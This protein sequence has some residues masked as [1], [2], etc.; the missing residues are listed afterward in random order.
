MSKIDSYEQRFHQIVN[1]ILDIIVE[2]DLKGNF[3]YASPQVYDILGY[4]PDEIIGLSG[5]KF[6]HPEDLPKV[7]EEMRDLLKPK[8]INTVKKLVM[9]Y[10]ALHKKGYYIFLSARGSLVEIEGN[11]KIIAVLSDITERKKIEQKLKDSEE[12][13]RPII[14]KAKEGYYEVD[15]KGNFTFF[16]DALSNLL[17]YSPNEL[18]GMNFKQIMDEENRKL[19]FKAYNNAYRTGIEQQLLQY[20]LITKSGENL[21]GETSIY[22]RYDSDG[23]KIGFSGF[24]RDI[25]ERKKAEQNLKES[26]EKYRQFIE[27]SLEGVWA[28]DENANTILVNPSMSKI[29]GYSLEEMIGK[30]LFEFVP[31]KDIEITKKNLEKRRKGIKEEFEKE[32]IRKDGKKIYTRLISSPNFV[33]KGNY[34]GSIAFVS[35][36]TEKK[37]AEQKLK[38]SEEKFRTIAEQSFVGFAMIQRNRIIYLNNT[39]SKINGFLP[40]ELKNINIFDLF[41]NIH[42]DDRS[43]VVNRLK[44]RDKKNTGELDNKSIRIITKSGEIRWI[45][46]EPRVFQFQGKDTILITMVDVTKERMAEI[47][48]KELNE[49]KSEFLRRAS[50]ELKTPLIAIKGFTNL[51]LNQYGG[52]LDSEIISMLEEVSQGCYRLEDIIKNLIETTKIESSKLELETTAEDLSFLIR[53]CIIELRGIVKSRN[54]TI[55]VNI[56]EIISTNFNKEQM[57]EVF[58]NL[59]SNAIKYTPPNGE[60]TI[61]SEIKDKNVIVSIQ[62]N[63]IGFTDK[64][65]EKVFKQF[66]KVERYGQGLDIGIDGSGLGLY[67]SKKIVELHGGKIWMESEGRYKGSIFYVLLPLIKI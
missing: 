29:L 61:K 51:V 35:D 15:L 10:R 22:I 25:T 1:N 53:F 7:L 32:F 5:F 9:E 39:V 24:L 30:N 40:E 37:E 28:I 23:R 18:M 55:H 60:I 2:I 48:L 41:K 52:T 21:Y 6:V 50:H 4:Y 56:D 63:G 65:K 43:I 44:N 20:E 66:G 42:P 62:D 58:T 16:N 31:Q 57:Y 47:E 59:L 27:D 17:K 12:K 38:E 36:I 33:N 64:E 34:I 26:E 14:E 8:K 11:M 3:T 45:N 46:M 49:L 13:Y 54:H 19:T 67:L